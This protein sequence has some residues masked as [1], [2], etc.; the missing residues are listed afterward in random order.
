MINDTLG[1][2]RVTILG[3]SGFIGRNLVHLLVSKNIKLRLV[4]REHPIYTSQK[5]SIEIKTGDITNDYFLE[6]V[7]SG[8]DIVI[9]L[10]SASF[11]GSPLDDPMTDVNLNL[12]PTLK[13][14]ESCKKR[15]VGQLVYVS[16][17]G[18]IYG[19]SKNIPIKEKDLALPI[20]SYGVTKLAIE[21]YLRLAALNSDLSVCILRVS[22]PYGKY[23]KIQKG[24]GLVDTIAYKIAHQQK[25][26]I[27]GDGNIVRDYIF[28]GDVVEAI[29]MVMNNTLNYSCYN[30][31]SG[32]GLSINQL[33]DKFRQTTNEVVDVQYQL[34]R[35]VD[36]PVNI[37]CTD[38]FKNRFGWR[39][40][41]GLE[42]EI[43][44]LIAYYKNEY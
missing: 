35:K 24:Q 40:K 34:G 25:I 43:L 31:G 22:N 8:S 26:T 20:S 28:V 2:L 39:C 18:A 29:Y 41:G 38:K 37:L 19:K 16:S 17:G 13:L 23:Q 12:I 5:N 10:A 30:I 9:H 27:W 14:I 6:E 4:G 33:L 11:P 36:V 3:S 32:V 21:N 42:V 15:G 7:I 1:D 44:K